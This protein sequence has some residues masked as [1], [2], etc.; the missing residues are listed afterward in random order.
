VNDELLAR[1]DWVLSV[2]VQERIDARVDVEDVIADLA[3]ALRAALAASLVTPN[4]D[5]DG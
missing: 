5:N 1:A 3:A 2:S 4:E